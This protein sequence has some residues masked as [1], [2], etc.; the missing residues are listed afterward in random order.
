MP[1][2]ITSLFM[3]TI[4]LGT[5]L[6]YVNYHWIG[7]WMGLE[8][9]TLAIIPIMAQNHHPRA[10]EAALKYFFIQGLAAATILFAGVSNTW[11]TGTSDIPPL[12]THPISATI[13]IIALALK[14]GL[15]PTHSWVPEVFQAV[16]LSTGMVIATWQKLAPFIILIHTVYH[17]EPQLLIIFGLT[18]TLIGAWGAMNQVEI[19]KILAYSSISHLGWTIA[20]ALLNPNL[21]IFTLAMYILTTAATFFTIKLTD[22]TK[23]NS[24]ARCWSKNPSTMTAAFL[25]FLSATGLP[26]LSTFLPKMLALQELVDQ[27]EHLVVF[28]IIISSLLALFFYL[29]LCYAISLVMLPDITNKAALWRTALKKTTLPAAVLTTLAIALLPVM[30]TI[31]AIVH[32]LA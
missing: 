22:A 10:S 13:L 6:V 2:A 20:V 32:D 12:I 4:G 14:M 15:A 23:I 26:P 21:A 31:T 17:M 19:R 5:A 27:S 24:L 29:R 1:A 28:I 25:L 11:L 30:P 3:T 16:D 18:S 8:I 9:N 7:A